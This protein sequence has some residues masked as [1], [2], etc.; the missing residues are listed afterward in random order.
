MEP[1]NLSIPGTSFCKMPIKPI[2]INYTVKASFFCVVYPRSKKHDLFDKKR[3]LSNHIWTRF[4]LWYYSW[5]LHWPHS[6]DN[7]DL[8]D[9]RHIYRWSKKEKGAGPIGWNALKKIGALLCSVAPIGPVLVKDKL[10]RGVGAGQWAASSCR[11]NKFGTFFGL[12]TFHHTRREIA[13]SL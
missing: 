11:K 1:T 4:V 6:Y 2:L 3:R 8:S 5:T 10:F 12:Y 7:A 13:F 9:N